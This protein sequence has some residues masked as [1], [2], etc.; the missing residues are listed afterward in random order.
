MNVLVQEQGFS[1]REAEKKIIGVDHAELGGYVAK[2]WQFSPKMITIISNHHMDMETSNKD[3]ETAV[4]YLADTIC[5]MMGIGGGVDGLSY[6]FH[7]DVMGLL[8]ISDV[9]VQEIIAGFAMNYSKVE[10]FL[11]AV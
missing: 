9:D 3:M 4:V 6:R 5:M 10:G 2:M 8:E 11:E 7:Q 1:F